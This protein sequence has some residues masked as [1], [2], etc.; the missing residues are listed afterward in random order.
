MK[1]ITCAALAALSLSVAGAAFAQATPAA[2]ASPAAPA[3]PAKP[4]EYVTVQMSI[5]VNKSAA[6]TWA[7]VG[8]YCDISAWM[9]LDCNMPSGTGDIGTVR[10]LANGRVTEVLVAKT[11]LAYGY[12]QPAVEGRFY[13]LYHGFLEARPVSA[14]TSKLL[15]TIML[16]VSNLADQAA[17]DA[18]LKQRRTTFENALAEMKKIAEAK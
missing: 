8:K 11:E 13:N 18:N 15:Y 9:K 3:A 5:D 12:T 6:D 2:P 7:K 17:K 1:F 16:D 10:K 4:P 14:T